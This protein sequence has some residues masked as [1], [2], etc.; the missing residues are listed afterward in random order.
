ME[1][2]LGSKFDAVL[3]IFLDKENATSQSKDLKCVGSTTNAD[4]NTNNSLVL[5]NWVLYFRVDHLCLRLLCL[6]FPSSSESAYDKLL[7]R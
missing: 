4:T 3:L 5:G 6:L 7:Q 2:S 1:C